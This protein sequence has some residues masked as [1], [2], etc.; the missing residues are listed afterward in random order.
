[1]NIAGAGA[2]PGIEGWRGSAGWFTLAL[3]AYNLIRLPKLLAA[4][5]A[6]AQ[7]PVRSAGRTRQGHV[8][9]A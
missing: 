4:P 6:E 5:L 3:A 8:E 7:N 9:R 2:R 1:M